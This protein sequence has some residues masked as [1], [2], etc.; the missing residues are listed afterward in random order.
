M[1]NRQ[2]AGQTIA[3]EV[4]AGA[5]GELAVDVDAAGTLEGLKL[6]IYAGA[7]NTLQLRPQRKTNGGYENLLAYGNDGKHYVD[8]DDDVWE[9]DLSI[10]V[11]KDDAIVVRYE[12]TDANNPHNF[13]AVTEIDHLNGVERAARAVKG[14]LA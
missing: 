4:A 1:T 12:N 8:G 3:Q 10:P 11:Q 6:R 5:S 14:V 2:R 13:R 7:E 9:W